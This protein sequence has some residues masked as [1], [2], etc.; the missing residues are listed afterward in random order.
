MA[1]YIHPR[2][3]HK[4]G[5]NFWV[6]ANCSIPCPMSGHMLTQ[7]TQ[8]G[9]QCLQL[10]PR[11]CQWAL[12]APWCSCM[13]VGIPCLGGGNYFC[14]CQINDTICPMHSLPTSTTYHIIFYVLYAFQSHP[15]LWITLPCGCQTHSHVRHWQLFLSQLINCSFS[16]YRVA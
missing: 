8:I 4:G 6:V 1:S 14:T 11:S 16:S 12:D 15:W 5:A 13:N 2:G 3:T 10:L 7:P 9:Y